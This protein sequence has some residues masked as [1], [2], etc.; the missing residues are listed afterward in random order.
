MPR[1]APEPRQRGSTRRKTLDAGNTQELF[2]SGEIRLK[3]KILEADMLNDVKGRGD[4][5]NMFDDQKEHEERLVSL[6]DRRN[7][8]K[9]QENA[10]NNNE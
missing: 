10:K 4:Y 2:K 8:K 5:L 1:L 7:T 9:M 6:R 3:R